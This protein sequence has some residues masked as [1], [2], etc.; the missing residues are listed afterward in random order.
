MKASSKCFDLIKSFEAFRAEAYPDPDSGWQPGDP[1]EKGMPWTYG[2]GSTIRL[3]GSKVQPGDTITEIAAGVL[4]A[5]Q[6]NS[7]YAPSVA[8]MVKVQISQNIFDSLTS[9][10]YNEGKGALE[11]STLL[12]LVNAKSND[13]YAITLAFLMWRKGT[14][15]GVRIDMNGLVKRRIF[16][17]GLYFS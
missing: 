17:A 12:K 3:D 7:E 8:R 5:I 13:Y 6:V 10:A 1:I 11:N 14:R 9:F 16:E 4:L 2:Y 15:N